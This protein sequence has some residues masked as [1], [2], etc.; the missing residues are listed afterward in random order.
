MTPTAT[1]PNAPSQDTRTFA[2]NLDQLAD[3]ALNVGLGLKPGQELVMTSSTDC[4]PLARRITEHA[5][6]AG[7]SLVTTFFSES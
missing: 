2:Q 5:Y 1:A 6:K 3:V 4:L 7:A